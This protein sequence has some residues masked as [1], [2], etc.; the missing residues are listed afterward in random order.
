MLEKFLKNFREV[1]SKHQTQASR[2]YASSQ[3]ERTL[4]IKNLWH[5]R[6]KATLMQYF[7]S[8]MTRYVKAKQHQKQTYNT[9]TENYQ[10]IREKLGHPNRA[11]R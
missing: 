7:F 6:P 10:N 3:H 11:R 4:T 2:N 5:I 9:R 8:Q 1:N